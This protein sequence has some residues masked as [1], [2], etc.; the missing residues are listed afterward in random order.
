MVEEVRANYPNVG[1]MRYALEKGSGII[2]E[3]ARPSIYG[4]SMINV[5]N[6]GNA[7]AQPEIWI[8]GSFPSGTIV[9]NETT[10]QEFTIKGASGL[11]CVDSYFGRTTKWT[12]AQVPTTNSIYEGNLLNGSC[13]MADD[14]KS[15]HFITIDSCYPRWRSVGYTASGSGT[16][17]LTS[18]ASVRMVG[19]HI[20]IGS[21]WYEITAVNGNTLTVSGSPSGSGSAM[22]CKLNKIRILPGSSDTVENV[23]VRCEDTFY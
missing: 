4:T 12:N 8:S 6:A 15:G 14:V 1:N 22:I 3:S 9:R 11:Y 10:G 18:R 13:V 2:A 21:T 16:V 7:P 23:A 17:T 5:L 19:E 20:R